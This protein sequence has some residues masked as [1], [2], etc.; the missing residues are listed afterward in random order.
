[1]EQKADQGRALIDAGFPS[2]HGWQSQIL[3][4]LQDAGLLDDFWRLHSAPDAA[5]SGREHTAT[6]VPD[7]GLRTALLSAKASLESPQL[8]QSAAEAA[9]SVSLGDAIRAVRMVQQS[10]DEG[11]AKAG[12]E[13]AQTRAELVQT[14]AELAKAR[15]Q[16]DELARS[17]TT[18]TETIQTRDEELALGR[19]HLEEVFRST[20]WRATRPL[21]D[22]TG[23]LA[24]GRGRSK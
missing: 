4:R 6:L 16:S 3:H 10:C 21:R 17:V 18:L 22:L 19:A 13:L 14:R 8:G 2:M 23:M 5:E 11:L 1:L 12:A 24:R 9:T 7:D 20:S 15:S